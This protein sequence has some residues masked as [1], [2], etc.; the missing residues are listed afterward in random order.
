MAAEGSW[1]RGRRG[2]GRR[3]GGSL[4]YWEDISTRTLDSPDCVGVVGRWSPLPIPA[5]LLV[6]AIMV[7]WSGGGAGYGELPLPPPRFGYMVTAA[8]GCRKGG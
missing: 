8:A 1:G 3:T 6:G 7:V 2:A 5:V 4:R